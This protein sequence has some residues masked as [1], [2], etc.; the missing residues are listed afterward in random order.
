MKVWENR[1]LEGICEHYEEKL[2]E[3]CAKLHEA[4]NNL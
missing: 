3:G 2:S 1:E 4:Q